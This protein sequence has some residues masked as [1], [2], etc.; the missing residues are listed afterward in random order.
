LLANCAPA[1]GELGCAVELEQVRVLAAAG[2]AS[3]QRAQ[4]QQPGGLRG[5]IAALAE[6]FVPAPAAGDRR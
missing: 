1:A 3:R 6:D 2:G 5:L 4:A